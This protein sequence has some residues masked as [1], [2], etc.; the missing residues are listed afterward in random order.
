MKFPVLYKLSLSW[1]PNFKFQ[2]QHFWLLRARFVLHCD[3]AIFLPP[4]IL[5]QSINSSPFCWRTN[6][7]RKAK[8]AIA[9]VFF[10]DNDRTN[11]ANANKFI[12]VSR[13]ISD[14][15]FLRYWCGLFPSFTKLHMV[16]SNT[17]PA[18]FALFQGMRS[19]K[20][21]RG[22]KS[23]LNPMRWLCDFITLLPKVHHSL[24]DEPQYPTRDYHTLHC[25][26]C[27]LSYSRRL[28]FAAKMSL[29]PSN[30]STS[31]LASIFSIVLL[32]SCRRCSGNQAACC[33][34]C[35]LIYLLLTS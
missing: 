33:S 24:L 22:K 3:C 18:F 11:S 30:H 7:W 10:C 19:K 34:F 31:V 8:L 2:F 17:S 25:S 14:N 6:H 23:N 35:I 32:F 15:F 21:H 1:I 5:Q 29:Y 9:N 27:V 26:L 16:F 20:L 13:V 28:S 12:W 4:T